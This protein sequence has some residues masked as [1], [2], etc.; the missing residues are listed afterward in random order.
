MLECPHDAV[1]KEGKRTEEKRKKNTS[2]IFQG[3]ALGG[4]GLKRARY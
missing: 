3:Q 4:G 1:L 2:E